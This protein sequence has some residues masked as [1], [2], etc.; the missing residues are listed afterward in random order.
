M[1]QRFSLVTQVAV[2]TSVS[3]S[4]TIE[5][6]SFGAGQVFVPVGSAITVL[7]WYGSYDGITFL[8]IQDG[9]GNAVISTVSAGNCCLIPAACF[10]CAFLRATD[11]TGGTIN[12]SLKA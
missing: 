3:A 2:G 12:L 4:K 7:T 10:A 9:N 5:F 8:P 11:P 1:L 6:R